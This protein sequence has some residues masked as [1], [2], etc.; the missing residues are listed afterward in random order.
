MPPNEHVEMVG[1][2][3]SEDNEKSK[4]GVLPRVEIDA[5][6]FVFEGGFTMVAISVQVTL[7]HAG[8]TNTPAVA[9]PVS[10]ACHGGGDDDA[11][12]K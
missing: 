6:Q 3:Q 4:E 12:D 7:T 1:G 11:V 5:V 8:E 10:V 2:N 9:V